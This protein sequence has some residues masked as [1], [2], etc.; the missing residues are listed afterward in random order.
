MLLNGRFRLERALEDGAETWLARDLLRGAACVVRAL[1]PPLSPGEDDLAANPLLSGRLRH[2]HLESYL[3]CE[4]LA[5]PGAR[6]PRW[7]LVS[8]LAP[9]HGRSLARLDA[10]A[11]ARAAL[12]ALSALEGL[13][14]L[15]LAHGGL[16]PERIH[17]GAGGVTLLAPGLGP[18]LGEAPRYPAPEGRAAA[19]E[20]VEPAPGSA[21]AK[22][23]ARADLYALGACLYEALA[24]RAPDHPAI[25]L[26]DLR[27]DAP[28]DLLRAIE[29]LL[30]PDPRRRADLHETRELLARV[31][32]GPARSA[33]LPPVVEPRL[34]GRAALLDEL[35]R[36]ADDA[37]AVAGAGRSAREAA[38]GPPPL[39]RLIGAPGLGRSRVL[40]ELATRLTRNGIAVLAT[41]AAAGRDPGATWRAA[42][43]RAQERGADSG[44]V[45]RALEALSGVAVDPGIR[46]ERVAR[47]LVALGARGAAL[48]LDDAQLLDA[49]GARMVAHLARAGLAIVTAETVAGRGAGTGAGQGAETGDEGPLAALLRDP[50]ALSG[51][52]RRFELGELGAEDAA[53]LVASL[54]PLRAGD[55]VA[56]LAALGG[57][58][59]FLLVEL[60]RE[61]SLGG[62]T[63]RSVLEAVN[64]RLERAT[65]ATRELLVTLAAIG[66][67][68]PRAA[69]GRLELFAK[70]AAL[71]EALGLGLLEERSGALEF[72]HGVARRALLESLDEDELARCCGRALEALEDDPES[73]PG[74]RARLALLARTPDAAARALAAA[75]GDAEPAELYQGALELLEPGLER[76]R[77]ARALA[78]RLTPRGAFAEARH[79]LEA[80]REDLE[81]APAGPERA[82]EEGW[83]C[84]AL[85]RLSSAEGDATEALSWVGRGRAALAD[86]GEGGAALAEL[87]AL[88]AH[89]ATQRGDHAGAARLYAR[90]R[91]AAGEDAA[92]RAR[93]ELRLAGALALSLDRTRFA[94]AR[95]R[96]AEARAALTGSA[97]ELEAERTLGVIAWYEGD[98]AAATGHFRAALAL[99]EELADLNLAAGLLNNLGMSAQAAG[100]LSQAETSLERAL[101]IAERS[102]QA[103]VL[104]RAYVNVGRLRRRRGDARGAAGHFRRGAAVAKAAGDPMIESAALSELG[105][106]RLEQRRFRAALAALRR[107]KRLRRRLGDAGRVAESELELGELWRRAGDVEAALDCTAR[108]LA[109][110]ASLGDP[111]GVAAAVEALEFVAGRP[112]GPAAVLR[113]AA[114]RPARELAARGGRSRA[115][116]SGAGGSRAGGSRAGALGTGGSGAGASGTGGSGTGGSG[117]GGSGA[118]GS[119]G[120]ASR[121]SAAGHL[122]ARGS[123]TRD[124]GSREPGS[125]LA[126]PGAR[127]AGPGRAPALT[128]VLAGL[129]RGRGLCRLALAT[130]AAALVGRAGDAEHAARYGERVEALLRELEETPEDARLAAPVLELARALAGEARAVIAAARGRPRDALAELE[131]IAAGPAGRGL[132]RGALLLKQAFLQLALA[133][134]A[135]ARASLAELRDLDEG[136]LPAP[137]RERR[138]VGLALVA[139][140]LRRAGEEPTARGAASGEATASTRGAGRADERGAAGAGAR[141]GESGGAR[142]ARHDEEP[143]GE[144]AALGA[145]TTPTLVDA[146]ATSRRLGDVA[147][148]GLVAA[149][150]AEEA[151]PGEA[152]LERAAARAAASR[153]VEGLPG[154]L[155]AGLARAA[156]PVPDEDALAASGPGAAAPVGAPDQEALLAMLSRVLSAGLELE[157]LLGAA[158]DAL[159]EATGAARGAAALTRA[160][161]LEV[162]AARHLDAGLLQPGRTPRAILEHAAREDL[163]VELHAEVGAPQRFVEARGD[164]GRSVLC[165]PL[166]AE[167]GKPLGA[168]YLDDPRH[169]ERFDAAARRL[170]GAF[171]RELTAA[172]RAAL[173]REAQLGE[174]S[175][176]AEA[177]RETARELG[178]EAAQELVGQSPQLRAVHRLIARYGATNAPVTIMG[179]SGTGKELVARALHRASPRRDAPF[180]VLNCTAVAATLLESELFGVEKGAFTGADRSR[181]GLFELAHT[182]TLFLDEV[183]DM[184][185]EMQA[186]LLRVLETGELRP[187]GARAQ[188]KV[189]VRIVSAT[190]HDL[191]QLVRENRFREDLLYRLNVLRVELPPLRERREDILLL[192][193][194]FLE[195]HA[196]AGGGIKTL[197]ADATERLL[198]HPWPGNVRELR[199][200]I[201]RACV[202]ESGPVIGGARLLLDAAAAPARTPDSQRP[203]AAP[204]YHKTYELRGVALNRRQQAAIDHLRGGVASL[205]N[206]DFCAL[207]EVSERTGLRDLTHLVEE[208]LLVRIGRRKGARYELHP[209]LR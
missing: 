58:N 164:A 183:G 24:G 117:A 192:A 10:P 105:N 158:L 153:L 3:A 138:A 166:R 28:S 134:A 67:P 95:R 142:A 81:A 149:A 88:E 116:G 50:L 114:A 48:L 68:L 40:A 26:A 104:C 174:L 137:L 206:R 108:A 132:R 205:T 140:A 146:L 32:G 209:S 43:E 128:P 182:G 87:H 92:L 65:A 195:R 122:A 148:L 7:L 172:L 100:D 181:K 145:R 98:A 103:S 121:E 41:R 169:P 124:A 54:L 85:A 61:W 135:D 178:D 168:L 130:V 29:A 110:Q 106:T 200:A 186:K 194:H 199:N 163:S 19:G 156:A 208:G 66:R 70:E 71:D 107:S 157:P 155:A 37:C 36:A 90:A 97:D 21:N 141:S 173:A 204:D 86:A 5:L 193:S 207:V 133:R 30:L 22:A 177:Y 18:L 59:P 188:V 64:A 198:R 120:G 69:L 123:T 179:E 47:P 49:E 160:G 99:A 11:L 91:E 189:D 203:G 115:G 113:A 101:D 127:D 4:R 119:R 109:L 82:R 197:D 12:A 25:P 56:R 75:P 83:T 131:A 125:R 196:N 147:L 14:G 143:S 96:V 73:S 39:L 151:G 13:A 201:D 76:A 8:E 202:L 27:P 118:G 46:R 16:R 176:L 126:T 79:A 136:A 55:E 60:A 63:P 154:S 150:R 34:V 2:P 9:A 171:A 38:P 185:L 57:G 152:A 191:R 51:E 15:G 77:A 80:A 45:A 78:E 42:L 184:S 175:R 20:G 93:L 84:L 89:T 31:S 144:G 112:G 52:P 111:A 62:A 187:V 44:E 167:G 180:I 94:E 165:V 72:R 102:G 1:E 23:A 53:A 159:L 129:Q 170:V 74:E 33:A 17:A 190:H 6:G 35:E 162:R 139:A 161:R